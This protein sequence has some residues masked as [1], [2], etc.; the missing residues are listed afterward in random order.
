MTQNQV[1][2]ICKTRPVYH[3]KSHYTPRAI[4]ENTYGEKDKEYIVTITPKQGTAEEFHA[5]EHPDA[6]PDQIK[7]QPNV[8]KGIFCKQCEEALGRLESHCQPELMKLIPELAA[9]NLKL[10][11]ID[12]V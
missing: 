4:S 3:I 9:G 5:R 1:C 12:L 11:E 2:A 7:P 8:G 10:N 6:T